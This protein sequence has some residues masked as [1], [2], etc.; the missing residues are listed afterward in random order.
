MKS[1]KTWVHAGWATYGSGAFMVTPY[2]M[3]DAN[4]GGHVTTRFLEGLLEGCLKEVSPTR[5][6][7]RVAVGTKVLRRVLRKGGGLIEAA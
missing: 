4:H 5:V 2:W 1:G 7:G 6:L 3:Q